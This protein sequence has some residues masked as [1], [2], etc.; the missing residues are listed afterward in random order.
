M[1]DPKAEKITAAWPR[2]SRHPFGFRERSSL[3]RLLR[4]PFCSGI[5]RSSKADQNRDEPEYDVLVCYCSRYPVVAGI[6]VLKK[7]NIGGDGKT[8]AEVIALIEAGRHREALLSMIMPPSPAST[9][10]LPVFIQSLPS[11]KGIRRLK[12]LSYLKTLSKWQEKTASALADPEKNAVACDLLDCYFRRSGLKANDTYDYFAFRFGQPRH[13]IAL[14]FASVIQQPR[15][16]I[17]DLGCGLG[18]LTRTLVQRAEGQPVIGM[19]KIFFYL[20][21]AKHWIAPEATYVCCWGEPSLPFSDQ[22]LSTAF[23]SDAFNYFT[24]KATSIRELKRITRNDGLIMLIYLRNPLFKYPHG[25]E[26]LLIE[27]YQALVADM[28]HRLVSNNAVLTRYLQR[29]GPPLVASAEAGDLALEP[30][31]SLIVSHRAEVFRDYGCFEEW[32]HAE[33][34]LELNPLYVEEKRD[35]SGNVYFRRRFPAPWYE[36]DNAECKQ[37]LPEEVCINSKTLLDLANGK[38]TEE[39]EKLIERCVLLGM[40][41]RYR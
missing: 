25:G 29:Q 2:R 10:L 28:P 35:G 40:P 14:S 7:G 8:S 12:N 19:D 9:E 16:P 4:C 13:L 30:T 31:L 33:G 21:I 17:L 5:L 11:I 18:H 41:E 37:Y 36:E 26:P 38:R 23:C 39:M 1:P 6:P 15:K 20:Y 3:F 32:P 24:H 27:G 34:R 22:A